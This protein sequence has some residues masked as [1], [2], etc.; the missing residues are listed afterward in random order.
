MPNV[1]MQ[2]FD[3]SKQSTQVNYVATPDSKLAITEFTFKL[4]FG[5]EIN[6]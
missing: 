4:I 6:T 5:K 3:N 2:V 1:F